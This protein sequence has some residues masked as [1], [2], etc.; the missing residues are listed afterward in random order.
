MTR[1]TVVDIATQV[2]AGSLSASTVLEENLAAI[3]AREH[4]IHAFNLVTADKARERAAQID[5]DVKAGKKVGRLAG[6]TIAL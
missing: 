3:A 2:A 6:V 4:E 5:A 1:R